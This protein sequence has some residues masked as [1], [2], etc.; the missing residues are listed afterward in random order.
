ME[1]LIAC[2]QSANPKAPSRVGIGSFTS[3]LTPGLTTSGEV[4]PE[5]FEGAVLVA[6]RSATTPW[7]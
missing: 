1:G 4:P 7:S 5:G 6:A 3:S 2:I